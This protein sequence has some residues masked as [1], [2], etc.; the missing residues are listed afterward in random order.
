MNK[1]GKDVRLGWELA[2]Q[3]SHGVCEL[4]FSRFHFHRLQ[5]YIFIPRPR[6]SIRSSPPWHTRPSSPHARVALVLIR[7]TTST[8]RYIPP[9]PVRQR[10]PVEHTA[11]T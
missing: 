11:N 4:R 2:R 6:P 9:H 8:K 5:L 7:N 10:V 3:V 1:G